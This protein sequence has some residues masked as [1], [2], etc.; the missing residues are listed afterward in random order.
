[1]LDDVQERA[2]HLLQGG[3]TAAQTEIFLELPADAIDVWVKTVPAFASELTRIELE[4]GEGVKLTELAL[5]EATTAFGGA[6]KPVK[7][8]KPEAA[9]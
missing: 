9:K 6:P 7:P 3:L 2:I 8:A 5:D 1:M 4:A